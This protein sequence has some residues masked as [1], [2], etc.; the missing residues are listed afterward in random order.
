MFRIDDEFEQLPV[1]AK[2]LIKK[3]FSDDLIESVLMWKEDRN[4]LIHA[5]MKQS[6]HTEDLM[7]VALKGQE[8]SKI[9]SS[10]T[11]SYKNAL[12]K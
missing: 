11:K 12:S 6:V 9:V 7:A 5:L 8:I 3:Y 1:C 2:G 4:K 10:K